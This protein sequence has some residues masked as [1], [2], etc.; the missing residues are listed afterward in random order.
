MGGNSMELLS[1][2][3]K[4]DG[5]MEKSDLLELIDEMHGLINVLLLKNKEYEEML[6]GQKETAE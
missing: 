2:M 4:V 6:E 3:R 1:W 5:S